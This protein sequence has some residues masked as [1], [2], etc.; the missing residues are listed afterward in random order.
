MTRLATVQMLRQSGNCSDAAAVW[1]LFRCCGSLAT[2]QILRQLNTKLVYSAV[3]TT[4]KDLSGNCSDAAAAEPGGGVFSCNNYD[5]WHV[6]QLFRCCGSWT[7]SWC[8]L[9][10]DCV[11]QQVSLPIHISQDGPASRGMYSYFCCGNL[12]L[13]DHN[14]LMPRNPERLLTI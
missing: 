5:L 10:L 2:V 1:Q 12:M 7:R 13:A 9:L 6:W 11:A 3:I 8:V 4:I 14:R